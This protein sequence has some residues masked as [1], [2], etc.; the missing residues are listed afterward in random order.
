MLIA[1]ILA[2]SGDPD[3]SVPGTAARMRRFWI[4]ALGENDDGFVDAA[5]MSEHHGE[6]VFASV[7][8]FFQLPTDFIHENLSPHQRPAPSR[9]LARVCTGARPRGRV[10]QISAR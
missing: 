5:M 7:P 2:A 9:H 6:S 4:P 10:G 1:V 3:G 8:R